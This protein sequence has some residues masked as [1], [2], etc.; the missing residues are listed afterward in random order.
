VSVTVSNS[1]ALTM[2]IYTPEHTHTQFLR[3]ICTNQ[4]YCNDWNIYLL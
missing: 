3:C 4:R 1:T 2:A